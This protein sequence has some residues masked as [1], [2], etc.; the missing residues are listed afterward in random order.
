[1][2]RLFPISLVIL[3][4]ILLRLCYVHGLFS[5]PSSA[6]AQSAGP[7]PRVLSP[8]DPPADLSPDQRARIDGLVRRAMHAPTSDERSAAALAIAD[9]STA[10]IASTLRAI[11]AAESIV[12]ENIRN[13]DTTAYKAVRWAPRGQTSPYALDLIQGSLKSTSG[14]LD[15]AIC[16]QGF[17]AI[18]VAER[19]GETLAYT[20][21]GNFFVNNRNE[22]VV[23]ID[24]GYALV[25]TIT[26]P[27]GVT[28]I[29][30][31]QDGT[32][33]VLLPG[34]GSKCTVGRISLTRFANPT[35]LAHR[36]GGIFLPSKDSGAAPVGYPSDK[37][38]GLVQQ[39][40]LEESNVDV[41]GE[42]MR[43]KFLNNWRVA[44]DEAIS[45][46]TR[47]KLA[48]TN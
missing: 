40:F 4:L 37:G 35:A 31:G 32:I 29:T 14:Q 23:G 39:G 11:D 5:Q 6:S 2:F 38:F 41:I 18:S 17:F 30:I 36:G 16:G 25:P 9:E 45:A 26:I 12:T 7:Q 1:M 46:S 10:R 24:N 48:S 8:I 28:D 20:R 13:A 33:Q 27:P 34:D 19:P 43:L 15:V 21:T 22:L 47:G 44:L 3:G 42:R